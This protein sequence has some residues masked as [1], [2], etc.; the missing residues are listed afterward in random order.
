MV[1]WRAL[2]WMMMMMMMMSS[3]MG[4]NLAARSCCGPRATGAVERGRVTEA[5]H[6]AR[7]C[8]D[9]S[10][11]TLQAELPNGGRVQLFVDRGRS[12]AQRRR[13]FALARAA[14]AL[15]TVADAHRVQAAKAAGTVLL[16]WSEVVSVKY[17][18][19]QKEA[20][21]EWDI[22]KLDAL[23]VDSSAVLAAF[24][25]AMAA[26]ARAAQRG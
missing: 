22:A 9:G 15:R 4:P 14:D 19:R 20:V 16:D 25:A 18:D 11:A 24:H 10:W 13:G 5:L 3:F 2:I 8:S 7:R 12:W 26:A 6:D 21:A 17:D 23:G 1:F